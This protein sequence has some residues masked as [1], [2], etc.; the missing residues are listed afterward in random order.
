MAAQA[1]SAD[2]LAIAK[3]VLGARAGDQWALS[4]IVR[5]CS[6]MVRAVAR[7]Y[8]FVTADIDDVEQDVWL[9]LMK[10][11][12]R[13]ERPAATRAWLCRV[14]TTAAWRLSAGNTKASL[15]A[16]VEELPCGDDTEELGL[17]RL[18]RKQTQR[19]VRQAIARLKPGDRR[20]VELLMTDDSSD[21]L[22]LS[23]VI[24]RPIGS[25][26]PTRQ[27]VLARLRHEPSLERLWRTESYAVAG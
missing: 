25:I 22:T 7:R 14:T 26:G 19:T 27:R 23:K 18:E 5:R 3:L 8:L 10:H 16:G 4:E 9:S 21:Y 17:R 2:A 12:H 24:D 13:I 20:L 15:A 1:V 11:L 6:P